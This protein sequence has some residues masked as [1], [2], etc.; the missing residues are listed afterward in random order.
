M[1]TSSF[2]DFG[3]FSEVGGHMDYI[4]LRVFWG[5]SGWARRA[6]PEA[7]PERP[8]ASQKCVSCPRLVSDES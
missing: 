4:S 3:T 1:V 7:L 6:C 5:R 2:V 8:S